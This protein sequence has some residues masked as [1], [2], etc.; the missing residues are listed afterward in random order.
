MYPDEQ[1][2]EIKSL[3]THTNT[4]KHEKHY[5]MFS[6]YWSSSFDDRIDYMT[7]AGELGNKIIDMGSLYT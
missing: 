4:N 1:N 2:S 3:Y 5:M 7:T 6:Y